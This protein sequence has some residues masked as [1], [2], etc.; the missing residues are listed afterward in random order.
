M[1]TPLAS[2]QT[3][4]MDKRI[5]VIDDEHRLAES[6][7]ALLRG[8]GY[9]VEAATSGEQGIAHL[10]LIAY[11]LVISDLRMA[12]IDG[13]DVM[14]YVADKCPSTAIIVIT[15]HASTESVIEALHQRVS[16]YIPKPFD[17]E[18]LRRAVEKVFAQQDTERLREDMIHM[19][20]HD[21]KVPLTSILGFA[22]LM[23]VK[24]GGLH[25]DTARFADIIISNSQKVL[26]MLDNY[27]TNARVERGKLE[28][29][30]MPIRIDELITEELRLQSLEIRKKKLSVELEI[31]PVP[32]EF[33]ADEPLLVR[34]I[35]NLLS[36][37]TKYTPEGG[38]IRITVA[39]E[40]AI[41]RILVANTGSGLTAEEVCTVFERYVR[42]KS[43]RG[44]A[45]T[46]LGLHVVK[47]VAIAHGGRVTCESA[48]GWVRFSLVLPIVP[49]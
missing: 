20:S 2:P 40:G 28:I 42:A 39:A 47:S 41:A 6:L 45:G 7:A 25:A 8:V 49:G 13:F 12:G 31:G 26:G 23:Q 3:Q 30:P 11:D 10:Q 29:A 34:A 18:F 24:E 22:Q 19:L 38:T 1:P 35:G 32:P 9:H 46:G 5:L 14:R 27:L 44:I 43:S 21:I 16:D 37:A 36:N 17:F 15:G 48:D 33:S 4:F